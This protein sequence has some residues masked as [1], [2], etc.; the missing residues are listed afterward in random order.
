[1]R[2]DEARAPDFIERMKQN[3]LSA[4]RSGQG[5]RFNQ[6]RETVIQLPNGERRTIEVVMYA[7]RTEIGYRVGSISR[8]ISERKQAEMRLEYLAMHDEMTGLP[9]RQL[10]HDRLV[11]A[12][13]RARRERHGVLAVMLLDLDNFKDVNDTY[14]HACG[15]DLLRL[16]AQRLQTCLR[17]SDTAARMG[18]DEFTIIVE[19]MSGREG[20]L[21]VAQKV[22]DALSKP[23]EIEGNVFHITASLG[24]SLYPTDS[25][26][27][28]TLLRQADIAMY[29]AKKRG[30]DIQ[31]YTALG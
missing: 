23:M 3:T 6:P 2:P 13:E 28:V 27:V 21:L 5:A 15:D 18:G 17:K 20:C 11:Q 14:G 4:L 29:Q 16:V 1:M 7:Y 30:N 31:F 26:D 12:L 8:D 19:E 22:L 24:I 25:E 10:F 9:N